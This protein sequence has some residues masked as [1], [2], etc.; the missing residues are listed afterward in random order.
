MKNEPLN[1]GRDGFEERDERQVM[2]DPRIRSG[3]LGLELLERPEPEDDAGDRRA[4]VDEGDQEPASLWRGVFGQEQRRPD[5]D[6]NA[7]DHRDHGDHD[8]AVH[9]RRRTVV[10]RLVQGVVARGREVP[11]A[12]FPQRRE[13]LIKRKKPM[14][15]RITK[16]VNPAPRATPR[17]ILSS[18]DRSFGMVIGRGASVLGRTRVEEVTAVK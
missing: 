5:G 4:Q 12:H 7:E 14:R 18:V 10:V 3:D 6:R 16:A 2:H 17:K 15:K 9:L 1:G 11:P 8:G 13:P